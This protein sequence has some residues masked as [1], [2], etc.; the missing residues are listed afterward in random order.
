MT[1]RRGYEVAGYW[2]SAGGA[3]SR[4]TE[5]LAIAMGESGTGGGSADCD[6]AAVSSAG[7]IGL[8]Q[9]MPFNAAPWGFT[10][11]DL[12]DPF[13]NARIAVGMSGDG[14]N[15]AAWDSAYAN[16]Q[17]SGRYSFLA[18]PEAGSADR[19]NL[20]I[21]AAALGSAPPT[22]PTTPA[23]VIS[24]VLLFR[25]VGFLDS[26]T[27]DSMPWL[28]RREAANAVAVGRLFRRLVV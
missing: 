7:A 11:N 6:D 20:P 27:R 2:T 23:T 16:I 14:Q 24:D 1:I 5:W 3:A 9:I 28:A 21:A 8:W 12:Y 10:P 13:V 25:D 19:A 18:W 15:C 17:A 4:R 26:L 22:D